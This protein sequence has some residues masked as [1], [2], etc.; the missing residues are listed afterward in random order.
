LVPGD[1]ER[2]E[3][4]PLSWAHA[5]GGSYTLPPGTLPGTDL[6]H[7]GGT[8]AFPLNEVGTGF[9]PDEPRAVDQPLPRVERADQLVRRW[10]DRPEPGGLAPCPGHGALRLSHL[11]RT[12]GATGQ[13]EVDRVAATLSILHHAPPRLILHDVRAGTPVML[14]GVGTDVRFLVPESP[15]VMVLRTGRSREPVP[16]RLR[17]VHIDADQ[18]IVRIVYG[19]MFHY[20]PI[21]PPSWIVV[22]RS[23][24]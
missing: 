11:A 14:A 6:P 1:P 19:H 4:V 22:D 5:F 15:V 13:R 24:H 21:R 3:T 2:F 20:S 17:G 8:I 18:R 12:A 23:T 10:D 7:P 9:Y 16:P